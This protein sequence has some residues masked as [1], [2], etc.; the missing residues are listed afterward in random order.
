MGYMCERCVD[1][2]YV[3]PMPPTGGPGRAA[4]AA[5]AATFRRAYGAEN[6][7]HR[8]CER[9]LAVIA[10][11]NARGAPF[12]NNGNVI[13]RDIYTYTHA[14][15]H[16]RTHVVRRM[17]DAAS[18]PKVT[19]SIKCAKLSYA[20]AFAIDQ[21]TDMRLGAAKRC[22]CCCCCCVCSPDRNEYV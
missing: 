2:V 14:R 8:A 10:Y 19:A 13:K 4:V 7:L 1:I 6:R 21:Q 17:R 18:A 15:A 20:R 9:T 11:Q 12:A 3:V 16:T 5:A 22:G